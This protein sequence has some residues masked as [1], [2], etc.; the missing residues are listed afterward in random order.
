MLATQFCPHS[1][2]APP[3]LHEQTLLA[4]LTNALVLHE[5]VLDPL[6][7]GLRDPRILA[8]ELA[9][10]ADRPLLARAVELK[11]PGWSGE[12][13]ERQASIKGS[14]MWDRAV[15]QTMEYRQRFGRQ[16]S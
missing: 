1:T 12:L 10:Q 6:H 11:W 3:G 7:L 4:L 15:E 13:D 14:R 9:V 2:L 16:Q 5:L 8:A